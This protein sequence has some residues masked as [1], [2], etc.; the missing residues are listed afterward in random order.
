MLLEYDYI[1][2]PYISETA[3]EELQELFFLILIK[4]DIK[5]KF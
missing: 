5:Q 3:R 1:F 2:S 4:A